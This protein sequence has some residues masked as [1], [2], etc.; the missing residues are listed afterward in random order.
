MGPT[1][2]GAENPVFEVKAVLGDGAAGQPAP[3]PAGKADGRQPWICSCGRFVGISRN[4]LPSVE[5]ERVGPCALLPWPPRE[6]GSVVRTSGCR[7]F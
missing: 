5:K 7:E 6:P 4:P 2:P 3:N 1:F